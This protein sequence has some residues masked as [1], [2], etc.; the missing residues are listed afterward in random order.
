M[1][2]IVLFS[3]SIHSLYTDLTLFAT[4]VCYTSFLLDSGVKG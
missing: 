2:F 4:Y 1:R 3:T